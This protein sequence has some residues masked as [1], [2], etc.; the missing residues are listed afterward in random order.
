MKKKKWTKDYPKIDPNFLFV[1]EGY[2]LR[3]TEPQARMGMTQIKKLDIFIK[4]RR[5]NAENLMNLMKEFN[6]FFVYQHEKK[7]SFHTWFGFTIIIKNLKIINR[8]KLCKFLNENGV[9]TRVIVSGNFVSQPVVKTFKHRVVGNLANAS[10]I[11]TNGFSIGIHQNLGNNQ[12]K[13]IYDVFKKYLKREN[14]L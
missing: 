9:E 14:L 2:N 1:N 7:K 12:I 4:K 6:D 5:N 11:M 10:K 13:Y 8:D 3:L